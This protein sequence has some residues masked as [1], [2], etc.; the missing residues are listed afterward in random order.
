[1]WFTGLIVGLIVGIPV[2]IAV[3]VAAICLIGKVWDAIEESR[4]E[5]EWYG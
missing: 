4:R 2:G 3:A 1:M 5:H